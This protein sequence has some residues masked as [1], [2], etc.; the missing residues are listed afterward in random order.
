[1]DGFCAETEV[2]LIGVYMLSCVLLSE[3]Y[4]WG[5]FSGVLLMLIAVAEDTGIDVVFYAVLLES[6]I[7]SGSNLRWVK[8]IPQSVSF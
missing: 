1:M 6:N 2:D 5:L 3:G 4:C 7:S 8:N